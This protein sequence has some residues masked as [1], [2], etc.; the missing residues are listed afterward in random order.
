M[1]GFKQLSRV[2]FTPRIVVAK[3][4]SEDR[5]A[6]TTPKYSEYDFIF[7]VLNTLVYE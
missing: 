1:R 4:E 5:A 3:H 2:D 6:T 7:L